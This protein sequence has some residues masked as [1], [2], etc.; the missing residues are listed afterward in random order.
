MRESL[1]VIWLLCST[2]V[3]SLA[4]RQPS[5]RADSL[6]RLL[7]TTPP[8]TTRVHLLMLLAWD[9]TDDDP[10]AAV[11]YGRQCLRLARQLGFKTGECR[12]LLMLG[13]AFLRSGN[14]PTAVQTQ[15][16]ARRLA[17][18]IP[19]AGGIIHADNALG[20][21]YAEQGRYPSALRYYF[22]AIALA[23]QRHDHVLL[24]PILGNVGQA[25]LEQGRL[26]S[27]WHYTWEGYRY[28]LRYHDQHSEIG[29]LSLLGDI[30]ARRGQQLEARRYYLRSIARS[31][32]MPV[33]Y[34][35]CRSYLGLAR[36]AQVQQPHQMLAYARQALLASEQGRYA[37]GVFEASGYLAQM[38][39][40]RGD[41]AQA[42]RYLAMA[43]GTRDSLFSHSR[44]VQIQALD[45]S[46]Y[47]RQ[48][49]LAEQSRQATAARRQYW[50]RVALLLLAGSIG[51]IYL[52]LNRRRLQQQ[53]AF[54]QERQQLERRRAEEVLAAE[55]RERRRIGAD[56]HDGLGQLLSVVKLNLGALRNEL[57][58][59][60]RK[61]Q[62][63]Q[64]GAALDVVDESVREV[65]GISHNL[66]PYVLIKRGLAEAVRSFLDKIGCASRLHI[67]F[68]ALGLEERLDPAVE[69]V[70]F[71]VVQE[72]VQNIL[73]HAQAT[74]LSVQLLRQPHRLTVLVEDN[75]VG[76]CPTSLA[77]QPNAG[78]GLRNIESRVAYLSGTVH[79][80]SR[81]GRGTSTTVEIPLGP[82]GAAGRGQAR[83]D[84][85]KT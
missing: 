42:Y 13:W 75:G 69:L 4:A 28:D 65:R 26:D 58:P 59:S 44:Q 36:L 51:G 18:A 25:Y 24:T 53:V 20:Y 52:L 55:E 27:A 49:T 35:L 46:E 45:F 81:P 76:F 22:R 34:A 85:L 17:E 83:P 8:D 84:R 61:S 73:K 19:Y 77:G 63:Q 12:A 62:R 70:V 82:A 37:K 1:V 29:D 43:A 3:G 6:Q 39:A 66:A 31:V 5:A 80:D 68:E 74:T 30:A 79:I 56:L 72:L 32:G 14:Y 41:S 11:R 23:R 21:A 10:L 60:L 9:R 57:E 7:A 47:L 33:S 78:I 40:A 64:F 2:A 71:R 16:Q 15:L 67:E 38:M 50:G 54:A 48:Q